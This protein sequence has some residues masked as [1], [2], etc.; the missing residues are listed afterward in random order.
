MFF[1]ALFLNPLD[2][3]AVILTDAQR[4]LIKRIQKCNGVTTCEGFTA[5][6]QPIGLR[7]TKTFGKRKFE[8]VSSFSFFLLIYN[9]N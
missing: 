4:E 2:D 3:P 9:I 5:S 8:D 6:G 1:L 7:T